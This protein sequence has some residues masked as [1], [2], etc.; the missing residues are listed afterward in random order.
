MCESDQRQAGALSQVE[1]T[2]AMLK[3]GA[4]IYRRDYEVSAPFCGDEEL[5]ADVFLAM[6]QA[7][8]YGR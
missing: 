8:E 1:V 4:A 2:E 5:V 6:C 7:R 3:A